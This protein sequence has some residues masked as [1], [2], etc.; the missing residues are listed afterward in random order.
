MQNL[1]HQLDGLLNEET[2][3]SN[4]TENGVM[5]FLIMD[6]DQLLMWL[7]MQQATL[8]MKSL[9]KASLSISFPAPGTYSQ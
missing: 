5:T 3:H 2:D 1:G 9:T 6:L 7:F 4:E 8:V